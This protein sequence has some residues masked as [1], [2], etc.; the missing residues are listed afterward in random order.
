[1][2]GM[3][4][5]DSQMIARRFLS[6]LDEKNVSP[7]EEIAESYFTAFRNEH[8]RS[9]VADQLSSEEMKDIIDYTRIFAHKRKGDGKEPGVASTVSQSGKSKEGRTDF[10]VKPKRGGGL[11][12]GAAVIVVL[13][14]IG[15]AFMTFFQE[16]DD[17]DDG[18]TDGD[19]T[20]DQDGDSVPN[21]WENKYGLDATDPQDANIDSD[22]DGLSNLEEYLGGGDP[23]DGIPLFT[24]DEEWIISDARSYANLIILSSGMRI[25]GTGNVTLFNVTIRSAEDSVI[26]IESNGELKAEDCTF[27]ANAT[28]N[29]TGFEIQSEHV[30]MIFC[31][32]MNATHD[33]NLTSNARVMVTNTIYS[34]TNSEIQEGSTLI[35]KGSLNVRVLDGSG[36]HY[37]DASVSIVDSHGNEVYSAITNATGRIPTRAI[38]ISEQNATHIR[39]FTPHLI[40]AWHQEYSNNRTVTM[41]VSNWPLDAIVYL[42]EDTDGDG[43]N[44]GDEKYLHQTNH[45]SFDTD[46]DGLGDGLE[47]GFSN[48]E[49]P[50]ST[51]DPRDPDTDSDGISDGDEDSNRDGAINGDINYDGNWNETEEWT[52]TDPND[53]DTE[54]DG[55][56]DGWEVSHGFDP[57]LNDSFLDPDADELSNREEFT[58]STHPMVNDTDND[59]LHDGQ[60]T[61]NGTN[62]MNVDSDNDGVSDG[63]EPDWSTDTDADGW[64]NALDPDSDDDLLP[65]RWERD[66]MLD[67]IDNG[68]MN[69]SM[70]SK[71]DPDADG[72]T[73]IDEFTHN[74]LPQNPD[75]DND[76]LPDG[77]EIENH[78]DPFNSDPDNDMLLDPEEIANNTDPFDSDTD[79][80]TLPDGWEVAH[81]LD[82]TN[83]LGLDGETGDPDA[84]GITNNDERQFG[85][86]PLNNDTDE[87]G[88]IDGIEGLVDTDSDGL[89][90]P[91]DPDSDNDGLPDSWENVMALDPKNDTGEQGAEGDPDSDLLENLAEYIHNSDPHDDDTDDD[92]MPDGWEVT[93]GLEPDVN[94]SLEDSDGDGIGNVEEWSIGSYPDDADSDGDGLPDGWETD[95]G[96][97]PLNPTGKNGAN[98]DPDDDG[99]D[100][101]GNGTINMTERYSNIEEFQ[102]GTDPQKNDTDDDHMADGWEVA[103][104]LRPLYNDSGEDADNDSLTNLDEYLYGELPWKMN[105]LRNDTDQDGLMDGAPTEGF[106]DTDNDG[107]MNALDLDS[108]NDG[109]DDGEEVLVLGTDPLNPD[110]DNDGLNDSHE[111]SLGSDP[112]DRDTDNDDVIDGQDP[113]PLDPDTDDD[114]LLDGEEAVQGVDSY[115]FEGEDLVGHPNQDVLDSSARNNRTAIHENSSSTIFNAT[116]DV[117]QGKYK[118]Y[119]RARSGPRAIAVEN[120]NNADLHAVA[121]NINNDALIVGQEGTV[122]KYSESAGIE[123]ISRSPDEEFFD[124]SWCPN[125]DYALIVGFNHS[126][127]RGMVLKYSESS[128]YSTVAGS[129]ITKPLQNIAWGETGEYALIVG[130]GGSL[131]RHEF[132]GD[133]YDTID[134]TTTVDLTSISCHPSQS[135][136]LISGYN[137]GNDEGFV[138]LYNDNTGN[139]VILDSIGNVYPRDASWNPNG[140]YA[141]IVGS[142]G[143]V[144]KSNGATVSLVSNTTY[145]EYFGLGWLP[146]GNALITGEDGTILEFDGEFFRDVVP[147]N[148]T[149]SFFDV[150]PSQDGAYTIAVG[151][152]GSIIRLIPPPAVILSVKENDGSRNVRPVIENDLHLLTSPAG[153]M[154][155]WYSTPEFTFNGT[156]LNLVADDS[157]YLDKNTQVFV[158]RIQLVN[159]SSINPK[160]TDPLDNDTDGDGVLDGIEATLNAQWYEAEDFVYDWDQIKNSTDASNSK[161]ILPNPN[162]T[163][164]TIYDPSY[165]YLS[166]TYEIF[167][168]ARSGQNA[169][170]ASVRVIVEN[171]SDGSTR[172]DNSLNYTFQDPYTQ[173]VFNIYTWNSTASFTV[174]SDSRLVI[175]ISVEGQDKDSVVL[176]KILLLKHTLLTSEFTPS[177]INVGNQNWPEQYRELGSNKVEIQNNVFVYWPRMIRILAPQNIIDPLDPDTDGDQYRP[178]DLLLTGSAGFLTDGR[179]LEI[180]TNPLDMDSDDDYLT[181]DI[182]PNPLSDDCD[183]DGLLDGVEDANRNVQYDPDN[184]ETDLLDDDTDNDGIIDG[185]EDKNL[186]TQKDDDETN[187]LD[188]DTDRDGI[189]D[190]TEIGLAE[191]E[192]EHTYSSDPVNP[193]QGTSFIADGDG[194]STD[195][196]VRDTD[197]DGLEDGE[198]DVNHNGRPDNDETDASDPDSDDDGLNDALELGII[199]DTDPSSTTDPNDPDS[200][201][202]GLTDGQEDKNRNGAWDMDNDE[203]DPEDDDTDNDGLEDGLELDSSDGWTTNPLDRDSDDDGITDGTEDRDKDGAV[204]SGQ[205]NGGTGPGESDPNDPD[206]DDDGLEDDDDPNPLIADSDGDTMDDAWEIAHGL[207][208]TVKDAGGDKDGDGLTNIQEFNIGT[209]P[210]DRDSDNDGMEDNWEYS[211]G[212]NPLVS[213]DKYMDM[214]GDWLANYYEYL[215]G[216]DPTDWDSD[217]DGLS[218]GQ[219]DMNENGVRDLFEPDPLDPDSDGDGI[220]D[221]DEPDWDEDT[222]GDGDTNVLDVDSDDDWLEDGV[223]DK[224]HDGVHDPGET[225]PIDEDSD[226]DGINDG[227]EPDWNVDTDKDGSINALDTDSDGDDLSDDE[228]DKDQDGHK[229]KG[230]TDPL[231][232]DSDNDGIE[233]GTELNWNVDTDG[234]GLINALDT[235]SDADG[236]PDGTEDRNHNGIVDVNEM[237]PIKTDSDSDGLFDAQEDRNKNGMKNAA[238]TDATD[239]D[240]DGDGLIDGQEDLN[241]NGKVDKSYS[242]GVVRDYPSS[243]TDPLDADSDGDGLNDWQ[244]TQVWDS[245]PWVRDTDLDGTI[246]G[247]DVDLGGDPTEQDLWV[248]IDYMDGHK[249]KQGVLNYIKQYY[250]NKDITIHWEVSD[251]ADIPHANHFT[252]ATWETTA[253]TYYDGD[254]HK[255]HVHILFVHNPESG[256]STLGAAW[257]VGAVMYDKACEDYADDNNDDWYDPWDEDV[258]HSQVQK[259]VLMHELGHC[260]EIIDRYSGGNERYCDDGHDKWRN[261]PP[262][263]VWVWDGFGYKSCVMAHVNEKN[264]RDSPWYCDEHWALHDLT[265]KRGVDEWSQ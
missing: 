77:A 98:G 121:H 12:K 51:T 101:D 158:D 244:E 245:H 167:I 115:W 46:N 43:I 190:G 127:Q 79:N 139:T 242:S 49:D 193:I 171:V 45:T 75:P 11:R 241:G 261:W 249:P 14:L 105:P 31:T 107:I 206:S 164:C 257:Y 265:D 4:P 212:L 185:T 172:L 229:D 95:H 39:Y 145:I 118:L 226:N 68:T 191:S 123:D 235:D 178:H 8:L 16:F 44:D 222:D 165:Q 142:E 210:D 82:P 260:I 234:N 203:T 252:D 246:D 99:W 129:E 147:S 80:D 126:S 224:D 74:T 179:E 204:D 97:D 30:Q 238:E 38:T 114:G 177:Y 180:G 220:K 36:D 166:G 233:D 231:D 146:D 262:G 100:R 239:S 198:E 41:T 113:D 84:D 202:D 102:L 28:M 130:G 236:I 259:V 240:T 35:I 60:E 25:T 160:L 128:G 223:E 78:T 162:G 10:V 197:G 140:D 56:H 149:L 2:E 116:L 29:W 71:G 136:A 173:K 85:L 109:L 42:G 159:M 111:F 124:A 243:E 5:E 15:V 91:L 174:E 27:M 21:D 187:P 61:R 135:I 52:E 93:H 201:D 264:S 163:M 215:I 134:S 3:S 170:D 117:P 141:L 181:D 175:N 213:Q 195:P 219:E 88:I 227:E 189:S 256:S 96:L 211:H 132:P 182:D 54:G 156:F 92:S 251:T 7:E 184:D 57:L 81:G 76:G 148:S 19:P 230:E 133:T 144:L 104:G 225:N 137:Q 253:D 122:L 120:V 192:G 22:G 70:G 200:D 250:N 208:P 218:D 131:L 6:Y 17:D 37:Q 34:F 154:Y 40:H 216:S 47:L 188:P 254:N 67:P 94:D 13:L 153:K 50:F 217:N 33:F 161:H 65:D 32:I 183:D 207:D 87:D 48:D 155:R 89:P 63:D 62:P 20:G 255:T 143:T 221:G 73:N 152:E 214:D 169:R 53:P 55:V 232:K 9:E 72:L 59:G 151:A 83:D 23:T 103:Y 106:N 90:D 168:R 112:L 228:E 186:N 209:D 196:L 258:S 86:H 247:L 125:G 66:H 26:L 18:D 237:S 108:D 248:E 205:W 194:A 157:S 69:F 199:G 110:S 119:V 150:S 1:M 24:H 64:I 138:Y 58:Y 263:Y 176:D